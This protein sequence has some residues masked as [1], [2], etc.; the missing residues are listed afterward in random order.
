MARKEKE[1]F[2]EEVPEGAPA[3][4]LTFCDC[5]TLLLTFFVLLLS[6]S[7]F[8]EGSLQRLNG[9]M[10]FASHSSISPNQDMLDAAVSVEVQPMQDDTKDGSEKRRDPDNKKIVKNPKKAEIPPTADAYDAETILNIPISEL[11]VGNSKIVTAQGKERLKTIVSYL[12][13][14]PRYV[15]IGESLPKES[16]IK[17]DPHRSWAVMKF[18]EQQGVPAEQCWIAAE[19]PRPRH[20]QQNRAT[21][22]VVLLSKKIHTKH[23]R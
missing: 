11:F 20:S 18:I 9:A 5:M 13:E 10:Q 23:K 8:D 2:K 17:A 7:S 16:D 19:C 15:V 6:F 3:W 12:N 21:M 1:P 22:Q 14:L 4:M